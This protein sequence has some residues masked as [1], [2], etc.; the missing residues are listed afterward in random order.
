M[1]LRLWAAAPALALLALLSLSSLSGAA[2]AGAIPWCGPRTGA[3]RPLPAGGNISQTLTDA[4]VT[5][6]L[7]AQKANSSFSPCVKAKLKTT[8]IG[9]VRVT[10]NSTDLKLWITLSCPVRKSEVSVGL[11]VE[12]T[13]PRSDASGNATPEV[14]DVDTLFVRVGDKKVQGRD[15]RDKD[16]FPTVQLVAPKPKPRPSPKPRPGKRP[17]PRPQVPAPAGAP[18]PEAAPAPSGAPAPEAAPT[19]SGAP[20]PEAG[21]SPAGAPAPEPTP[22]PAPAPAA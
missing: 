10:D 13:E 3:W 22:G 19:P 20:A 21:P 7:N 18:V 4:I 9:C 12:A 2:A 1:S 11:V 15:P 17:R 6:F 5:G 16:Y 8:I 14:L